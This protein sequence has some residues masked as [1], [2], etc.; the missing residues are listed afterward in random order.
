[1]EDNNEIDYRRPISYTIVWI[2]CLIVDYFSIYKNCFGLEVPFSCLVSVFV[3]LLINSSLDFAF[4]TLESIMKEVKTIFP[5]ILIIFSLFVLLVIFLS[6]EYYS[7][8]NGGYA[9]ADIIF[10]VVIYLG[11]AILRHNP[12]ICVEDYSGK[13]YK[14]QPF[15]EQYT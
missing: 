2:L 4:I 10:M 5:F 15:G 12:N 8:N 11:L 3:A 9:L 14:S 1:M 7:T 13:N 6:Y